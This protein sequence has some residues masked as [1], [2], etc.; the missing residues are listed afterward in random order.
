[1]RHFEVEISVVNP[2]G[3]PAIS[4]SVKKEG[5]GLTQLH[6]LS[7]CMAH[8][9]VKSL[10]VF[11]QIQKLIA[12]GATALLFATAMQPVNAEIVPINARANTPAP[13]ENYLK[14]GTGAGPG[15]VIAINN[16]FITRDGRPWIPIM[17]EFH[18]SRFPSAFWEEE[19]LK[20]KAS[21][22]NTVATYIIWNQHELEP[23][24]LDWSG[25]RDLRRFAQ[26]CAKHGLFLY[27]R[28]GPWVHAETR[29]GGLPDWVVESTRR[30]TNDPAYLAQVERFWSGVAESLRGLLWKDGGPVIGMQVENEYNLTGPGKGP[31]HIAALKR[32]AHKLNLDLPLYTVTGWD[33]AAYPRGDVAPVTGAYVDEPWSASTRELPPRE[34]YAFRFKSRIAAGLGAQ[35]EG[36]KTRVPDADKDRDLTPFLGAEYGPGLPVMYR[37]RPLVAPDDIAAM[38]VTQIGSGLNLLGY[39]MYHGGANPTAFERGLE[40][41]TA[42]GSANDVPRIAYDFQAPI[43]QYG[44]VNPVNGYLRPLHYFLAT[45]GEDLAR[46]TAR[47]PDAVPATPGD[48]NTLRAAVRSEGDRGFLFVNNYVRQY[49]MAEHRDVQFDIHLA[50][51]D[52]RLPS[53]PIT[54][55]NKAYFFWPFNMDLEGTKLRWATA[56]PITRIDGADGGLLHV[57][58]AANDV[59]VEFVF[60]AADIVSISARTRRD[61]DRLIADIHPSRTRFVTVRTKAN[62]TIRL[63]VLPATDTRKLWV[64]D[65]LG[66]RRVLLSDAAVFSEKGKL[67]LR[68]RGDANFTFAAW[69]A[70]PSLPGVRRASVHDL[71]I[72]RGSVN[73]VAPLKVEVKQI[74]QASAAGPLKMSGPRNSAVQPVA[75]AFDGAAAWDI[76]V[77]EQSLKGVEDAW[78]SIDYRGDVGRL[79]DGNTMLDDSFWDGRVWHVGLKRFR[80]RLGKPWQLSI[81]PLPADAPIYLDQAVRPKSGEGVAAELRSLTLEPEY[82]LELGAIR[83]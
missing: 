30:R 79:F 61:G 31:D 62:K 10:S 15:G 50:D 21:G 46:M 28:P 5:T 4:Q 29:M 69:P 59:P 19:L 74:R 83:P 42:S 72:Y 11:N 73:A 64:G 51:G 2:D 65:M 24:K 78:L 58:S 17:G 13:V 38:I 7:C 40:E 63:L 33:N 20:M 26:L 25:D 68:Q 32:L 22:I 16:S 81:V 18:F 9:R 66:V 52:L 34:A 56:Q 76:S 39:Y 43:G 27:I 44:E 12:A 53:R 23:D 36:D 3:D 54:V 82:Q 6:R 71:P 49:A 45:F 75:E 35:T 77:P 8:G 41:T 47:R 60:T 1:M 57:F 14:M 80:A 70:L 48:L 37:R 67:L 55:K